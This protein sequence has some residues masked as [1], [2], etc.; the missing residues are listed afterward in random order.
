MEAIPLQE[1]K[2]NNYYCYVAGEFIK[3]VEI[4]TILSLKR[5]LFEGISMF[6]GFWWPRNSFSL[7]YSV[8]HIILR[9][10]TGEEIVSMISNGETAV[11][12]EVSDSNSSTYPALAS[13]RV[14]H[15][16]NI[17]TSRFRGVVPHQNGHWG[18]QIYANHQR[19]WL[20][21]FK[22]EKEAA[23]AYDSAA[24]KLRS[25][26]CRRNFP[27]TNISVEEPKFQSYYS[28]EAV[29][30]MIKDGTYQSKLAYFS[31]TSSQSVETELSIK[32][33]KTQRNRSLMCKE[34]FQ[35][36]LTPSD[37]GKLNRL[38]IPKRFAIKFFSHISESVEQNIGGNKANDGQLAFYD[39]AMKLWKFRYCYWKSSQSYVFTRGWN[40][41]VKEKQ[42]K[43]ND[44]IA[45][46]LCECRENAELT[47]SYYMIDV[48]N[49]GDSSSLLES[50]SQSE[51]T[52][53]QVHLHLGQTTACHYN[54]N[55]V[56]GE[57]LK[58]ARPRH[59]GDRKSFRLFGTEII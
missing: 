25:G 18:C 30:K 7:L 40:R 31:S 27:I 34:L 20:G 32:L 59:D 55:K 45:F 44:T 14:M 38:V 56:E 36:E 5:K 47:D 41:F 23:M 43:A 39:K 9:N 10:M 3:A 42:L 19:I 11:T 46:C 21:T 58:E 8:K 2:Y 51:T 50:G 52:K 24:L 16:S 29:L 35:K 53:M 1:L 26:D 4:C 33:T 49:E 28:T 57:G 22:S 12:E 15:G 17:C 6:S 13:K 48:K 37:V 54:K